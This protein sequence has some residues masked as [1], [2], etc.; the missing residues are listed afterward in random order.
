MLDKSVPYAGVL[1]RRAPGRPPAAVL[2][3]GYAFRLFRSGDE[4]A[5]ARI[6]TSVAEFPDEQSALAHF[7]RTFLPHLAELER[8]CLFIESPAGDLV[9]T[10]TAW[11][12]YSGA[13]RDP[14]FH[15]LAVSPDQQG[16]GLGK[17]MAA[18]VVERMIQI[19]GDR[20]IYLHTQTWSHKAIGIY[21]ALGFRITDE[22]NLSKYANEDY[23][24]AIEI[25]ES[26][27]S[28]KD[29]A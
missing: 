18:K 24:K 8:R 5:W 23:L 2:P 13:R 16:K 28:R 20:P 4:R 7:E 10:G 25:L 17:A 9:A 15:W 21:E 11:W 26:I 6:E 27:R 3:E 29:H 1:M 22:K 14:W 19:E 12:A